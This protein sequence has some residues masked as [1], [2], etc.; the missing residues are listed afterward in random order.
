MSN[1][2]SVIRQLLI[3]DRSIRR[4]DASQPIARSTIENWVHHLRYTHSTR[5]IQP[6]KYRIVTEKDE[7]DQ[8][9]P[10]LKWA[11]YYKDWDGPQLDERPTAYVIQLLDTR[12]FSSSR[13]DE[14]IQA[15]ALTLM[16]A[17]ENVSSCI[18]MAYDAPKL[19]E[20]QHLPD[21]L[22]PV[23]VIAFGIGKETVVIE[24]L[25][26][27]YKYFKTADEV[28]HVPKRKGEELVV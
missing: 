8:I 27:D 14:G 17:E 10:L 4:F 5:N 20:A 11:A 7:V 1:R 26:D 15:E 25:V 9:F 6:L 3:K 12:I 13:F 19:I 16:A 23:A 21:Y 18:I 2:E 24:D 22:K 28:H